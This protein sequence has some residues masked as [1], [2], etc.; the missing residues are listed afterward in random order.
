[1]GYL[2]VLIM[3]CVVGA[4]E[5]HLVNNL[6]HDAALPT[7]AA[8]LHQ[9]SHRPRLSAPMPPDLRGKW[10]SSRCES[11][12]GP[13][14][15][16]RSYTFH[17]D[18]SFHLA[19]HLYRDASC[20][21]PTYTLSAHGH[22]TLGRPSWVTP[23]GTEAEYIVSRVEVVSHTHR[24]AALV[25]AA[26]NASCPGKVIKPWK[27]HKPH[28]VLAYTETNNEVMED[29]DCGRNLG[30]A[31]HELQLVRVELTA[32]KHSQK[33]T[34]G[35]S[36]S[37][38]MMGARKELFLGDIHTD[39]SKQDLYRPTGYQPPLLNVKY[40]SDCG[41]CGAVGRSNER[42]PA[43]LHAGPA[44]PLV[45][46]GAW[47]SPRCE[48]RPYGMFLTRHLLFSPARQ[49][50]SMTL[51]YYHDPECSRP[52]FTLHATGT[53]AHATPAPYA[54]DFTVSRLVL[55]PEDADLASALNSYKGKECGRPGKW[56]PKKSQD[57]TSTGGCKAV[58]V[59]VPV[60][61]KEIIRTGVDETGGMWLML[62]QTATTPRQLGDTPRPTSWG[63][64]LIS[65]RHYNT[66][67][68]DNSLRPMVGAR[69]ASSA[70]SLTYTKP[71]I[72]A[73]LVLLAL[74]W[75]P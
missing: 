30:A 8:L 39:F 34:Q 69:V 72:V 67:E 27:P 49:E 54:H 68:Q 22:L 44:L 16:L 56:T 55:T 51:R 36:S 43:H 60:V 73:L 40:A 53:Y 13:R 14:H 58:G 28:T 33:G 19:L 12:P 71:I 9:A 2:A 70:A 6:V 7:C 62:G 23:G 47:A 17:H 35:G 32:P 75:K 25:A 50:W 24:D 1:M 74:T 37:S 65:C 42:S 11:R 57:V 20:A 61:E 38:S 10:V 41:V 26:V 63:P 3:A 18:K 15:V 21:H 48:T 31:W 66:H 29:D 64:T 4:C 5:S 46:A 52:S 59:R 45:L